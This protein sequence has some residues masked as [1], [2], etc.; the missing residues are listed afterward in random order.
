MKLYTEKGCFIYDFI[1][2]LNDVVE[3][4]TISH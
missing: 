2:V 4:K 3:L 1:T